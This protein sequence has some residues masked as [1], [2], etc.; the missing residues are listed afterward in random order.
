[1][2]KTREVEI[3][4]MGGRLRAARKAKNLTLEHV[5]KQLG[6]SAQA[7][8]QWEY[9]ETQPAVDKLLMLVHMLE[10]EIGEVL[11]YS[12]QSLVRAIA[13]RLEQ[14]LEYLPTAQPAIID[15]NVGRTVVDGVYL[16][17]LQKGTPPSGVVGRLVWP[18]I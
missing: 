10:L 15:T 16:V 7:V 17:R 11:G 6:V 18:K 3:N 1:M 14:M 8:S 9:G 5:G 13:D 2:P 4:T 12:G